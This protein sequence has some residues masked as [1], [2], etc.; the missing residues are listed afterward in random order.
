[1]TDLLFKAQKYMNEE[2]VLTTKGL[3][4]KQKKDKGAESQNKK[5]ERKDSHTEAKTSKSSLA[6][7]KK[8]LNFIPLIMP[9]NKIL[10]QIKDDPTL[11]WPKPLSSSLK[12]R[13]PKKY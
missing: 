8:K 4:G 13:D 1:M 9:V 5:K 6:S 12:R 11:K 10:M 7:S 2:D 3:T